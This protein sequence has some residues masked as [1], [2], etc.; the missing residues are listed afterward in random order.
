[1]WIHPI[2]NKKIDILIKNLN[3]KTRNEITK[4]KENAILKK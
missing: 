2:M 4:V 3:T 1:M